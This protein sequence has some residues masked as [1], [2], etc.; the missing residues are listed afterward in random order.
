MVKRNWIA[1]SRKDVNSRP[2]ARHASAVDSRAA[3]DEEESAAQPPVG[4]C[5]SANSSRRFWT[6]RSP[7]TMALLY[8][9]LRVLSNFGE[10]EPC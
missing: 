8:G 4:S 1:R 6:G 9:R 10:K 2:S 3:C 7:A 5:F